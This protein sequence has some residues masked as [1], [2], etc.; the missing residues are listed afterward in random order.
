MNLLAIADF[1]SL[2]VEYIS[3][4]FFSN[5]YFIDLLKNSQPLSIH[6]LF[7]FL[8]GSFKIF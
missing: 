7:G 8:L 1:P 2:C 3:K 6:I 4:S 5:H